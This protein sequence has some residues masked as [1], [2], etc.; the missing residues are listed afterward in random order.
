MTMGTQVS[1]DGT[2]AQDPRPKFF[3]A[4]LSANPFAMNRISDPSQMDCDVASIHQA[5]FDRLVEGAQEAFRDNRGVGSLLLGSAGTGK[6]HLLARLSRWA[7]QR[8]CFVYLHNIQVNPSDMSRYLLKGCVT[9]LAE[10][11]LDRLHETPL[12]SV[13]LSAIKAAAKEEQIDRINDDNREEI[14]RRLAKRLEG[15]ERVFDVIFRFFFYVARSLKRVREPVRTENAE[16][17]ALAVRWLKGDMLDRDE[18]R[19]IGQKPAKPDDEVVQLG[20]DLVPVVLTNISRLARVS[21][22]PFILCVDQADNM[23]DEQ[24]TALGRS[25]HALIDSARNMYVV[26]AGVRDVLIR[27]IQEGVIPEAAADRLDYQRPIFIKRIAPDQARMVVRQR[28]AA[29]HQRAIST[30]DNLPIHEDELFPLGEQWFQDSLAQEVELR[31]RDVLTRAADRWRFAQGEIRERGGEAWLKSWRQA[32]P[33]PVPN[34]LTPEEI[35][36]AIDKKVHDKLVE[37]VSARRLQPGQLP[38]DQGNLLGLTEKL[39]RQCLSTDQGYTIRGLTVL[40]GTKQVD[41]IVEEAVGD[42]LIRNHVE[43]VVTG[44]KTSAAARLRK[45]LESPKADHRILVTECRVPL[46]VGDAGAKRLGALQALGAEVFQHV[47]LSF[48]QYAQM[49]AMMSVVGE[50]R[51]QDLEVEPRR[52]YVLPVTEQQVIES[53][54]R[55]D[56]YRQ[57]P[58]LRIFLTQETIT[59]RSEAMLDEPRFRQFVLAKLSFLMGANM[60]ELARHYVADRGEADHLEEYLPR[61][62]DIVLR[63][64]E[65]DLLCAKPWDDDIYLT[66]G[67][68]A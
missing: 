53:Y 45:L 27:K 36:A 30:A 20:E 4:M 58:L 3:E 60:I 10:D 24:L 34:I 25:L 22:R 52:G 68:K 67:P 40:G 9:R 54:H 16:L 13:V 35:Q 56:R 26:V 19:R 62:R 59:P 37:A 51:S 23:A 28:L 14:Y 41:L 21:G 39:L 2:A 7:Q 63:M 66:I 49:D 64:H 29:F 42:R 6:S 61:A 55:H 43:F 50:A 32:K 15:D 18:A 47:D 11:R 12:F 5:E 57:Q 38:S 65:E 8:A 48:E 17:A 31:P 46:Q 33:P 1:G 44:S